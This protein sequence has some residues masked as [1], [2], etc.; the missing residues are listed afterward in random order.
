MWSKYTHFHVFSFAVKT[1]Q[2]CKR[3]L[4]RLHFLFSIISSIFSGRY[5]MDSHITEEKK[6][7]I[8]SLRSHEG[9]SCLHEDWLSLMGMSLCAYGGSGSQSEMNLD[10]REKESI[11]WV[12]G[13]EQRGK[14]NAPKQTGQRDRERAS[15]CRLLQI[16]SGYYWLCVCVLYEKKMREKEIESDRGRKEEEIEAS[17]NGSEAWTVIEAQHHISDSGCIITRHH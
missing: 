5:V 7:K 12:T 4:T 2:V 14:R 11:I 17:L 15:Y 10:S 13:H 9:P 8:L 3:T 16:S 1:D 6:S